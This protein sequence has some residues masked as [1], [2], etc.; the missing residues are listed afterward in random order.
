MAST[1]GSFSSTRE[2]AGELD[3]LMR[4]S[5]YSNR[6]RFLRDAAIRYAELMKLG[7][8]SDMEDV[9]KVD[10]TLVVYYQ[11]EAG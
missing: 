6:S 3:Q 1:I 2:F 8:I 10:G 4:D 7:D 9:L 11:H 5:G